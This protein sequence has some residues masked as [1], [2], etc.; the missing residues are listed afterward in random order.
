MSKFDIG[1]AVLRRNSTKRG[2]VISIFPPRRGRQ[3][4][5]VNWDGVETDELE[6]NLVRDYD[7]SDPFARCAQGVFGSYS[8]Y[9]KRNTSFKIQSSNNSTIS[10]LKASKTLFRAYQFKPLLKFLNSPNRRLLVADEVGLGKTIEAGHIMLELKARRELGNMLIVCPKSLQ[11][12]WKVELQDKFGLFFYIYEKNKDLI[13]ELKAHNGRVRAIVNYEKIRLSKNDSSEE[14]L[15]LIDYINKEGTRFSLVICDEAHRMRNAETQTYKGADFLMSS[16]DSVLFLTA[17][18]VMISNQNLYNLLHLLDKTRYFNYQIFSNLL[19]QNRPIIT[20]ISELNNNIPL[21]EIERNLSSSEVMISYSADDKEISSRTTTIEDSFKQDPLYKEI[22]RLLKNNDTSENRARLHYLLNS[23]S[24]MNNVFSRTRKREVTMDM[25][26][27]ERKPHLVSVKLNSK[28][29]A[30]YDRVINEYLEENSY[31]DSEGNR[32]LSQGSA[33]GL[34]TKK[35]EI[36]S[37]VFGYL[38]REDDLEAGIDRFSEF[39][40]GKILKLAQIIEEVFRN[41][42]KKL[43][44]FALYRKTLNYLK[45]RLKKLGYHSLLIHG[46]IHNRTEIVNEFKTN[47]QAHI[48]LSSEVGSEGLD[49]QFCSSMVN[50]D[51]PWNPMVVEQRIGRIDRFGQLSETVNIYNFVVKSSIQEEIYERLLNRIGIF[52]GTIGDLEAILDA[53]LTPGG[54]IS[55]SSAIDRMEKEFYVSKLTP[56]ERHR[57]EL[58]VEQAIENERENIRHLDEGLNN[59]LTNDSYFKDEIRRILDKNAYISEHELKN[60]IESAING[61]LSTCSL[62]YLKNDIYE[63]ALSKSDPSSL[64]NFLLEYQPAGDEYDY[65]FNSFKRFIEDKLSFKLTFNQEV[66]YENR[67]LIYV[68]MYHPLICA[69]LQFFMKNENKLNTSFSYSLTHDNIMKEG[70]TYYMAVFKIDTSRKILGI[71]KTSTELLPILYNAV[72]KCVESREDIVDHVFG[73]SQVS[74]KECNPQPLFVK[75]E[76]IQDLRYDLQDVIRNEKDKRYREIQINAES[77]KIRNVS[78]TEEYYNSLISNRRKSIEE[79]KW[80]LDYSIGLS[81]KEKRNLEG[82]IRLGEANIRDYAKQRDSYLNIFKA[83]PEISI[84]EQIVSLNL[85]R[86]I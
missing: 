44:I 2:I 24:V 66:A 71:P 7:I 43:V 48:L 58:E 35:R 54:K 16:A 83:D 76:L 74:G 36:A 25:S 11:E 53:P 78:Q 26:Q 79:W 14:D 55:I 4:Y 64:K 68:N 72:D 28:E 21:S 30:E 75:E 19:T 82:A 1:T 50:Y 32:F 38:N 85:V 42:N 80:R 56:E 5:R 23:I 40:D 46:D 29:K 70:L 15:S 17:T 13:N 65:L 33:L 86:I 22:K 10:S 31:E 9:C 77:E 61:P 81:D 45:I 59:T 12:K 37:S 51:L 34:V 8:E 52:K 62:S 27:P 49:M 3:L 20:A 69:C 39:E 67:S 63:F 73:Q 60:Y 41:G 57:K 47:P 84:D 18:P 6:D